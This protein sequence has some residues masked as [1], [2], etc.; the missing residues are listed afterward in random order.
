M[1]AARFV[2]HA[3]MLLKRVFCSRVFDKGPS[4]HACLAPDV[5]G[6]PKRQIFKVKSRFFAIFIRLINSFQLSLLDQGH[7]RLFC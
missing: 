5:T 4:F 1:E 7:F 6:K 2:L 3:C